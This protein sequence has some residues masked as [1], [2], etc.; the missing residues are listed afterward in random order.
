M[1]V[2][3]ISQKEIKEGKAYRVKEDAVLRFIAWLKKITNT[4]QGNEL[5][6]GEEN[7]ETY[8][9]RRAEFE[10]TV[11]WVGV[12]SAFLIVLLLGVPT[13]SLD[14]S[15]IIRGF[16]ASLLVLLLALFLIILRY[17]P[18]I[19]PVPEVIKSGRKGNKDKGKG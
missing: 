12:F 14:V 13:L 15:G 11:K 4:Y 18:S 1:K 5:Y 8:K 6:V 3:I 10:K 19:E 9:K 7:L 16:F 2:D 17:Y